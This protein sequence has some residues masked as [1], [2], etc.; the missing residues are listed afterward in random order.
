DLFLQSCPNLLE[1][2]LSGCV[3]EARID[4]LDYRASHGDLKLPIISVNWQDVSTLS[5]ELINPDSLLAKCLRQVRF[6]L[7]RPWLPGGVPFGYNASRYEAD[8]NALLQMLEVNRILEQVDGKT[9]K[10]GRKRTREVSSSLWAIC[11]AGPV[12]AE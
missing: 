1:L 11:K 12:D 3:V 8:L 7:V 10:V 9:D 4:F 6:C 2:R 5:Q